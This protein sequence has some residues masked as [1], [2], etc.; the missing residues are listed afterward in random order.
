MNYIM[1]DNPLMATANIIWHFRFYV[2][3]PSSQWIKHGPAH[4]HYSL[5][6]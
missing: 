5:Q 4:P 1:T 6:R 3:L 2:K